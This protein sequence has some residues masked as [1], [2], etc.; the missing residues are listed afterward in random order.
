M[1]LQHA[2]KYTDIRN[3]L[4]YIQ[5]INNLACIMFIY[6]K[7]DYRNYPHIAP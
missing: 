7:K 6:Y 5:G 2:H 4:C 3:E 1:Y